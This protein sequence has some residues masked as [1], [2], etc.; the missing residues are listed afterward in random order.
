VGASIAYAYLSSTVDIG[1][2]VEVGVFGEWVGARVVAEPLFD[3][4]HVRIRG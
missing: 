4:D 1:T 3:P 2:A